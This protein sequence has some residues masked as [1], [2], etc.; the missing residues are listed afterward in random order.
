MTPRWPWLLVL[1]LALWPGQLAGWEE[2][3]LPVIRRVWVDPERLPAELQRATDWV[4]VSRPTFEATLAQ[5]QRHRDE[6]QRT[7]WLVSA[8]YVARCDA[9]QLQG[10]AEWDLYSPRGP[11]SLWRL[12]PW[13]LVLRGAPTANGGAALA[14][15]TPPLLLLEGAGR[16]TVKLAWSLRG[17]TKPDGVWLYL[18]VPPAPQVH[19]AIETP[20]GT[21]LDWPAA[22]GQVTCRGPTSAG[23]TG[24]LVDAGGK[25]RSELAL[26]VRSPA[27]ARRRTQVR[28]ATEYRPAP[29][30]WTWRTALELENAEGSF[31]A[32]QLRMDPGIEIDRV[33]RLP[34]RRPWTGW[35]V[36]ETASGRFLRLEGQQQREPRLAL[37]IHGHA[38]GD[39]APGAT[40][41]L[42]GLHAPSEWL[43]GETLSVF[44]PRELR[45]QA[46][47]LGDYRLA[48]VPGPAAGDQQTWRWRFEPARLGPLGTL[49]RPSLRWT[50]E[51][52]DL[53]IRQGWWWQIH[54][55]RAAAAWF[56][57]VTTRRTTLPHTL[58][59]RLPTGWRVRSVDVK[60]A[61]GLRSWHV[62]E[63]GGELVLTI[64]PHESL[65]NTRAMQLLTR[66]EATEPCLYSARR[67]LAIPRVVPREGQVVEDW[68]AYSLPRL[69]NGVP[70]LAAT[71]EGPGWLPLP[72]S[73]VDESWM[74]AELGVADGR[75]LATTAADVAQL[76][77]APLP[78]QVAA[79]VQAHFDPTTTRLRYR[80]KVK[81]LRGRITALPLRFTAPSPGISWQTTDPNAPVWTA[82]DS[83]HGELRWTTPLLDSQEL[84]AEVAAAAAVPLPIPAAAQ[85]TGSVSWHAPTDGRRLQGKG[86]WEVRAAEPDAVITARYDATTHEVTWHREAAAVAPV[87]LS[88]TK[89]TTAILPEGRRRHHYETT[90]FAAAAQTAALNLPAQ[91]TEITVEL[92]GQALP[93]AGTSHLVLELSPGRHR[94]VCRW[95]G[96][97]A[98]SL[99][100]PGGVA[101]PEW[102]SPVVEV[103]RRRHWHL[104]ADGWVWLPPEG[105]WLTHDPHLS[106]T[107][108]PTHGGRERI[109]EQKV[110]DPH[111]AGPMP[112]SPIWVIVAQVLA[113]A[114]VV[115]GFRRWPR[116]RPAAPL[117]AL[118]M[119]GLAWGGPSEGR[120]VA[121]AVLAAAVVVMAYPTRQAVP[122]SE[123][124]G[125]TSPATVVIRGSASAVLLLAALTGDRPIDAATDRG[126]AVVFVVSGTPETV[127]VPTDLW[128]RIE[129]LAREPM[130]GLPDVAIL[131]GDYRG[132]VGDDVAQI[133]AVWRLRVLRGGPVS[134]PITLGE[135]RLRQAWLDDLPT[136]PLTVSPNEPL[137]FSITGVGEHRL[138]LTWEQPVVSAGG[139]RSLRWR[140][141]SAPAAAMTLTFPHQPRDLQ[142]DAG[143]GMPQLQASPEA[144]VA[145]ID[146]GMSGQGGVRW[147]VDPPGPASGT[148][149][150]VHRLEG[151]LHQVTLQ[152]LFQME[153]L[154]AGSND[155]R[156]RIPLAWQVIDVEMLP[157][158]PSDTNRIVSWTVQADRERGPQLAVRFREPVSEGNQILISLVRG[159]PPQPPPPLAWSPSAV[160]AVGLW[161]QLAVGGIAGGSERVE[162]ELALPRLSDLPS[163]GGWV[164]WL[165]RGVVGPNWKPQRGLSGQSI[166]TWAKVWP[167]QLAAPTVT[168]VHRWRGSEPPPLVLRLAVEPSAV[169]MQ[170]KHRVSLMPV[171]T[172]WT[173]EVEVQATKRPLFLLR[174]ELAGGWRP[175]KVSG[176]DLLDWQATGSTLFVWFRRPVADHTRLTLEAAWFP[177]SG[178][179]ALAARPWPGIKWTDASAND[180]TWQVELSPELRPRRGMPPATWREVT[181]PRGNR[182][183]ARVRRF[184]VP[185]PQ[186]G[187]TLAVEVDRSLSSARFKPTVS[188]T[189]QGT[190]VAV[191]TSDP[192]P[193]PQYELTLHLRD[194]AATAIVEPQPVGRDIAV[195]VR[196][197]GEGVWEWRW[198]SRSPLGRVGL[199]VHLPPGM[200]PPRVVT[201]GVPD[202]EPAG[203]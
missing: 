106:N 47:D 151:E 37:E 10:T 166:E 74:A 20:A 112:I 162:L 164:G 178:A 173:A 60:P 110:V 114:A 161:Q 171:Y 202:S 129:R 71:L 111:L 66:L 127:F 154:S 180:E 95:E 50:G 148:V 84:V 184:D 86:Y 63:Q 54:E 23:W 5:A 76:E 102:L 203:P 81:P 158:G 46:A 35:Q 157:S 53:E 101:W 52:S 152:S 26:V 141:P 196:Q 130:P 169:Q 140:L 27:T 57:N 6:A 187:D 28:L 67:H 68:L 15:G 43:A 193:V 1:L 82:T 11:R 195:Q 2:P 48:E 97:S 168:A 126:P 181:L 139:T 108:P 142:T 18:Q 61:G 185:P 24:W 136:V 200:G 38:P 8:N 175:R 159:V 55:P 170:T 122:R 91:A 143:M 83:R 33:L 201:P 191:A 29:T 150:E 32:A 188:E 197:L 9:E 198:R 104:P 182:D 13:N 19:L 30:G 87:W 98:W 77:V 135:G 92:D 62:A 3:T 113:L 132:R 107:A 145:N 7:P 137:M 186:P 165:G 94:L 58:A 40:F 117:L 123:P 51:G 17:E 131:A 14:A 134:L 34:A 156:W 125:S 109:W 45:W 103:E 93:C 44:V 116:L 12:E 177:A 31:A 146:L 189:A 138:R 199:N 75:F 69:P 155:L 121:W 100:N 167:R 90:L 65:A 4:S 194:V 39:P 80:M 72:E 128:R 183:D 73:S 153:R 36:V 70:T 176:P 147:Q 64:H 89:L 16:Q 56:A 59:W 21:L 190:Q 192:P 119:A 99:G 120:D 124:S 79:D 144:W 78:A 115:A 133:E 85:W 22:R 105:R 160:L 163:S 49:R 174:G 41:Q 25:V 149:A 96:E 179:D 42:A 88:G 172:E 118:A